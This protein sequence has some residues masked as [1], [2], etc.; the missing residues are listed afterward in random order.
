MR[1]QKALA[2][3]LAAA[4]WA[5][6]VLAVSQNRLQAQS[7]AGSLAITQA[8][9]QAIPQAPFQAASLANPVDA[10]SVRPEVSDIQS[11]IRTAMDSLGAVPGLSIAVV[12][13]QEIIM[14]TGFGVADIR[15]GA[16]VDADTPFYIA[17]ATKPFSALAIALMAERGDVHLDRPVASWAGD[18]ALPNEMAQS[19]TLTDLLSH[20]SGLRNDPLAF[21]SAFSGEHTP[22]LLQGLLART[23]FDEQ[24]PRGVFRYTNTGYNLAT[25]LIEARYGTDWRHL[26]KDEVLAPAGMDRST[27]WISEIR[28]TPA[29][30]AGHLAD[31]PQV[32]PSPL[33]KVD[34]TMQ[35]AGGLVSTANDMAR[36]LELQINDG[37]IDGQRIFP[38]GLVAST[39]IARVSQDSSFGAYRRDGYGLGWQI[40]RYGNEAL[41]HHFG[42]FS[43]SRAHVSLMPGRN[44]GV[45]VMVNEDRVAGDLADV[46]A[47][48]VYDRFAQRPDL[49]V[50]YDREIARLIDRRDR[51]R[52]ALAAAR[53]DRLERP[54]RLSRPK[55]DLV[56]TYVSPAMGRL[57]ITLADEQ[58]RVSIGMLSAIAEAHTDVDT[59]RVELVPLQG[60]GVAFTGPDT[61]VF[62]GETFRRWQGDRR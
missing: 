45:V 2:L 20:R 21:R 17:S 13:G 25:T 26:V 5:Q 15:T 61:L 60:E 41:I 7:Q 27:A 28:G 31:L 40:G 57:H 6:P 51:L 62:G 18:T 11:F 39:H 59:L 22:E 34:A 24:T 50:T 49:K 23:V 43:G 29:L 4:L 47:N 44:L 37:V 38:E 1:T 53:A 56:G 3:A 33:Q 32:R 42:N 48:Y 52:A 12:E 55:G 54:W 35:S 10:Q 8:I 58:M 46:V 36:W 30:A 16:V 14:A 9:T 19:V